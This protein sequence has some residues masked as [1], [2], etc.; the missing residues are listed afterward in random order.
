[1]GHDDLKVHGDLK[2]KDD[3]KVHGDLK[4]KDDL[5]VDGSLKVEDRLHFG[6]GYI[7]SASTTTPITV[8][9]NSASGKVRLTGAPQS[10]A[11]SLTINNNKVKSDSIVLVTFVGTLTP[12]EITSLVTA[13]GSMTLVFTTSTGTT[14]DLIVNFLVC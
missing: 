11:T 4:V 13:D 12:A 9:L 7:T 5:K 14:G 10:T 1:M 8:N 6:R 2:V 3:L